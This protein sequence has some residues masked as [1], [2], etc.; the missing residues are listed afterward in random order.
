MKTHVPLSKR[1]RALYP[2]AVNLHRARRRVS[3][4]SSSRRWTKLRNKVN[5]PFRIATHQ[6]TLLRKLGNADM[7][8][9]H[10]KVKNLEAAVKELDGTIIRPGEHF[11]F[12]KSIGKPTRRRGFVD[13]MLL[14][15]GKIIEGLGGGMC[16][17]S[18]LLYWMFLHTP[19]QITERYRHSYDPFPDSGRTLPFGT[20]ATVFYNYIDLAC[21]NNTNKTFQL[22]V[23]VTDQHLKGEIY[24]SE[25]LDES[26]H[27]EERDHDFVHNTKDETLYRRNKIYRTR[28]NRKTGVPVGEELMIENCSKVLYE[29]P[30][31]VEVKQATFEPV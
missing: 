29:A 8:L 10:N 7:R 25:E 20:G 22:R 18:N 13:G 1:F 15:E 2:L 26:Y 31:N 9:Q 16:Q 28:L 27:L 24:C 4:V 19:L 12:W 11:S 5:L 21:V 23:W 17:A 30:A 6:S 14:S 3:W